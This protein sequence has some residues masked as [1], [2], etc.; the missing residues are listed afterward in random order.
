MLD[1]PDWPGHVGRP[2]RRR[3]PDRGGR[4]PGRSARTR[5]R[6]RRR[7]RRLALTVERIDDGEVSPYLTEE[8][9]R[10]R[11]VRA[12]RSD[13]RLLRLAGARTAARCCWSA[14]APGVVPLMSMLR[15]HAARGQRRRRAAAALGAERRGHPLPRRAR[16]APAASRSS[17][18]LTRRGP[19]GWGGFDAPRRRR[20]ARGGRARRREQRRTSSSAGR[21][22]FVETVA[23]LLRRARTRSGARSAPSASARQ[24]DEMT[25]EALWLDGNAIAGLLHGALRRAR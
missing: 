14:A 13:R 5:S 16:R 1:V 21:R 6:R 17:Y 24:E 7:T 23:D 25:D 2:A 11:R 18:T 4:L 20:H 22:P 9:A 15:H 19:T 3:A 12:A 10:G 8:L